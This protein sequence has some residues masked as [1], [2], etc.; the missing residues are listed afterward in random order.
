MGPR[1]LDI[2]SVDSQVVSVLLLDT[3]ILIYYLE[4][5]EPYYPLTEEIFNDIADE[6]IRGSLSAISITEF[7]TKPL[8]DGKVIVVEYFKQFLSALSIQVLAVTYD[9]K[10]TPF[11]ARGP[12][13][14]Q[15]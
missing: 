1:I 4:G 10:L 3:S 5:V 7:V 8:A 9:T 13:A 6:N 14:S 2:R 12:C 11:V 15:C